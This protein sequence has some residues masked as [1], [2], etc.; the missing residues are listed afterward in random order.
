[1][2]R[3]PSCKHTAVRANP[4]DD[5]GPEWWIC[6]NPNCVQNAWTRGERNPKRSG[7]AGSVVENLVSLTEEERERLASVFVGRLT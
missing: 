2:M 3:C 4:D 6:P 1:M 7:R 5:M